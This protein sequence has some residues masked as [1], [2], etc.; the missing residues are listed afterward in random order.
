M[1]FL[2]GLRAATWNGF[3]ITAEPLER[4]TGLQ[5]D[6]IGLGV[7]ALLSRLVDRRRL[8]LQRPRPPCALPSATP[9]AKALIAQAGR[10]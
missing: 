3:R 4:S 8:H 10:R 6:G 9:E 2:H 7:P 5:S 1:V